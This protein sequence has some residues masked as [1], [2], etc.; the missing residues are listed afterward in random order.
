MMN[1]HDDNLLVKTDLNVYQ[2]SCFAT[3]LNIAGTFSRN[4]LTDYLRAQRR[5]AG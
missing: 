4:I 5:V 3:A 1:V 2:I